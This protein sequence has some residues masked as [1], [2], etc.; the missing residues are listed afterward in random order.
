MAELAPG[1]VLTPAAAAE[2][3]TE[4]ASAK[5][6]YRRFWLLI[7]A[8][9]FGTT[10]AYA[11]Y[12]QPLRYLLKTQLHAGQE[13]VAAFFFIG[14][15]TNYIK[16]LAGIC[17]DAIPLFGTRRRHYLLFSLFIC[18][19]FWLV[20]P[21]VPRSYVPLLST[22][23]LMH[24]FIVFISTTLGGL[25]SEGGQRFHASGRLSAQRIGITRIVGLIGGPVG[26]WL[27]TK[28]FGW[29]CGTVALF[30]LALLPLFY[31][32]LRENTN[33]TVKV[34]RLVEVKRQWAT[35]ISS[36]SLW[37]AAGLVVL[38]MIAPGFVTPL[39]YYQQDTLHFSQ[40]DIGNLKVIGACFGMFGAVLF[41]R[42]CGRFSLR[43]LLAAGIVLHALAALLYLFY[44][45]YVSATIITGLYE[46]SNALAVLPLYDLAIRATPKGSEALG[47]SV[48]MSVWNLA[49]GASDV[50]GSAL[51]QHHTVTFST[52][53][54]LNAATT[55]LV[56]F[57][58]PL[59]PRVLTN[60][61][62]GCP[63]P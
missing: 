12:D 52:L 49:L 9:W 19:L 35:L 55:V 58:V 2:A 21:L 7:G 1:D 32:Q 16:P 50:L 38:I 34:E 41:S 43:P 62:D 17:T 61:R 33:A 44:R 14:T 3:V 22:F 51:I 24:V 53:I 29:T 6:E 60:R 37:A 25:M 26:G 18:A 63:A 57:A 40:Q 56:L 5:A 54:W 4:D 42:I 46:A 13:L 47:Y 20:L 39:Y 15:F 8:G 45:D 10:V 27:A 28:N 59:L 36:R 30:H 31:Q 11:I 48:M 23:A